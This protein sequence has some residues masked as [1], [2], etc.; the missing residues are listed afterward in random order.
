MKLGIT[1]PDIKSYEKIMFEDILKTIILLLFDISA[2][3][4][5]I[6]LAKR[7]YMFCNLAQFEFIH[8]E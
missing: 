3:F 2:L 5:P 7:S 8:W 1:H 6:Q 4:N